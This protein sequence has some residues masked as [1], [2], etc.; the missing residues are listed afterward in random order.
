MKSSLFSKKPYQT[1]LAG[2]VNKTKDLLPFP[3]FAEPLPLPKKIKIESARQRI[4]YFRVVG[5]TRSS[6]LLVFTF[7]AVSY[8][9]QF[10]SAYT[11]ISIT[12]TIIIALAIYAFTIQHDL[13]VY[14]LAGLTINERQEILDSC[15][16]TYLN[17][18]VHKE[19][20]DAYDM[21]Y[22]LLQDFK[23]QEFNPKYRRYYAAIRARENAWEEH[24]AVHE[25]LC[26]TENFYESKKG[27]RL[28]KYGFNLIYDFYCEHGSLLKLRKWLSVEEVKLFA[29]THRQYL[30]TFKYKPDPAA[31]EREIQNLKLESDKEIIA[32]TED[33]A[34]TIVDIVCI[35]EQRAKIHKVFT[36]AYEKLAVAIYDTL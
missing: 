17:N 35:R 21:Y 18:P 25:S 19:L 23:C 27:E 2:R 28:G 22:S 29:L 26:I 14:F 32:I 5:L 34:D 11:N 7:L 15:Y 20:I 31:I 10:T 3:E 13:M 30:E 1:A 36:L 6:L 12:A 24:T 4:K 33:I 9:A 8:Q 16:Q